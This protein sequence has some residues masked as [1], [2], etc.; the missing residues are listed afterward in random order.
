MGFYAK[1]PKLTLWGFRYFKSKFVRTAVSSYRQTIFG[2]ILRKN[3]NT[4]TE[5]AA[6]KLL[7]AMTNDEA[8]MEEQYL[9]AQFQIASFSI[10]LVGS[11]VFMLAIKRRAACSSKPPSLWRK[12]K[13]TAKRCFLRN[14][15]SFPCAHLA[16]WTIPF[17][18][19]PISMII[20]AKVAIRIAAGA[21]F[22]CGLPSSAA[23]RMANYNPSACR[24]GSYGHDF[25]PLMNSI[26][27]HIHPR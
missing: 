13:K 1:L 9:V 16:Q 8:V 20:K 24:S 3:D 27:S 15:P 19:V 7:S 10:W 12:K 23:A 6:S 11:I 21:R 5:D 22:C 14:C 25:H 26:H 2:K 17:A 4:F 18:G